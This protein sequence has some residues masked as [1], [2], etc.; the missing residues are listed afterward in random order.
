MADIAGDGRNHHADRMGDGFIVEI[1]SQRG[2]Q[3]ASGDQAGQHRLRD[4]CKVDQ[5]EP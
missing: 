2:E 1:N 4:R 3:P 5:Q